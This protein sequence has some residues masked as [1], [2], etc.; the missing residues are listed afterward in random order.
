MS[1]AWACANL[2]VDSRSRMVVR[3]S[4]PLSAW[5]EKGQKKW[6]TLNEK[7]KKKKK[8]FGVGL[9][10][11]NV[12]VLSLNSV[13]VFEFMTK[14]LSIPASTRE[15]GWWCD[16]P[17][18]CQP[19]TKKDQTEI[20][21]ANRAVDSR[22]RMVVRP[23]EPLSAWKKRTTT[24]LNARIGLSTREVVEQTNKPKRSV[25]IRL[26]CIIDVFRQPI[27]HLVSL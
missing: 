24:K 21:C 22:S 12:F 9:T 16:P 8:L 25:Y 26:R 13:R 18:H 10:R 14:N 7:K 11:G 15:V 4:E 3:P 6:L 17:S 2:T 23:S 20:E 5:N 19:E 27:I 1:L